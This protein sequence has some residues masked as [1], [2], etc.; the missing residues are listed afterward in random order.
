[1]LTLYITRHAKASKEDPTLRDFDRPLN[2]RGV[3]DTAFMAEVFKGRG[4]HVDHLVSSPAARAL[5]TAVGFASAL[6]VAAASIARD[7]RIYLADTGMLLRVV[8]ALPPGIRSAMIFGHNPGLSE[9][10][11][12][13][14][15]GPDMDLPTCATVRIDLHADDWAHVSRGNGSLAWTDHPRMH[16]EGN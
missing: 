14:V 8:N 12:A 11:S 5:S 2:E 6:G 1:M 7:E 9:L 15:G 4:E 16:A 3:R 10:A 13:L